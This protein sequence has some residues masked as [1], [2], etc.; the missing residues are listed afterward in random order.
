MKNALIS[1]VFFALL[2]AAGEFAARAGGV[3]QVMF[4][5]PSSVA[6]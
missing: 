3:S 6:K 1:I 5:P 2:I 4:P